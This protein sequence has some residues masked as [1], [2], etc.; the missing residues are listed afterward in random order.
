MRVFFW[1][2]G[3]K[4]VGMI[5]EKEDTDRKS[6]HVRIALLRMPACEV[7]DRLLNTIR[8]RPVTTDTITDPN[9]GTSLLLK[10]EGRFRPLP[11]GHFECLVTFRRLSWV[12]PYITDQ[13]QSKNGT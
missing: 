6:R 3:A 5:H 8:N 1:K 7:E 10:Q 13:L 12:A 9:L 4:I 2:N 11:S